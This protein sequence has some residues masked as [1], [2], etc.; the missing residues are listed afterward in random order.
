MWTSPDLS[1][2]VEV[3]DCSILFSADHG[4]T[5]KGLPGSEARGM[6]RGLCNAADRAE[7]AQTEQDRAAA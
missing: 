3:A 7:E 6:A 4:Q 2:R 1:I 5:W